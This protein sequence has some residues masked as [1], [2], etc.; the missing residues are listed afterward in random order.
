MSEP[1]PATTAVADETA[2]KAAAPRANA[3]SLLGTAFVTGAAVMVVEILGTR[4]VGPVF[5]VG[6]FAWS[7]L[8]SVT[9]LALAGGYYVGGAWADRRPGATLLA[10]IVVTAGALVA[11]VP[12][13]DAWVLSFAEVLGPAVGPT[14]SALVLFGPS[15]S[16]LGMV[17]PV[18]TR[19][20]AG[21]VAKMGRSVGAIYAISTAGSLVGTLITAHW[22]IPSFTTD[23]ILLGTAAVLTVLGV[24]TLLAARHPSALLALV[25]PVGALVSAGPKLP[26]GFHVLDEAHSLLGKLQVIDDEQRGVRFMRA[27]HSII[28]A[29]Y[30]DP[31]SPA[32]AFV[33]VLEAVRFMRPQAQRSLQIGLG[34][35]SLPLAL[36]RRGQ[37]VDVVEI[38]PEVV[39][40]AQEHFAF[41]T[42]GEIFVEDARTFLRGSH[43]PYDVIV[44]DTFTGGGTPE[45]LLSLELLQQ[46]R[47]MLIPNGVLALNFVGF[48]SGERAAASFAVV[49]TLREVFPHV[50]T[51]VDEDP[52]H[53]PEGLSNLS[54]FASQASLDFAIP[55]NAMF[56]DAT[57]ERVLRSLG[58]WEVLQDVPAG[59]LITD[60]RNPLGQ[61]QMAVSDAHF[62]A[63]NKLL[64]VEVWL[65]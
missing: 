7:A 35:G 12:A 10:Q 51:F 59:D 50:R 26:K 2:T 42:R 43:G 23:S 65:N 31:V 33:H 6:L 49:R 16:L 9:L 34:I 30:V 46:V 45:H 58:G 1:Q 62:A 21:N 57:C 52:T 38:D 54:M 25:L 4:V 19:A 32:F 27:D 40:M 36:E 17:G 20:S 29:Q 39:R 63:M 47:A 14:L 28:G 56:D 44:H 37:I 60:A 3:P 61:L 64:P 41:S 18:V 13:L 8:L 24:G 15:L 5:G 53:D 55:K 48:R 22:L 11:L